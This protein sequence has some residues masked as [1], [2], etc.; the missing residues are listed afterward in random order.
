M[1]SLNWPCTCNFV[2]F[3]IVIIANCWAVW[4][5]QVRLIFENWSNNVN[6]SAWYRRYVINW[7]KWI[8]SS[9]CLPF[10]ISTTLSNVAWVM[11]IRLVVSW[12]LF[13]L[14]RSSSL[15]F[16]QTHCFFFKIPFL[17]IFSHLCP[18]NVANLKLIISPLRWSTSWLKDLN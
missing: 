8:R 12:I 2:G 9:F 14:T 17:F 7:L 11:Q 13:Q 1:W 6:S 10:R 3:N 4:L 5:F 18:L 15:N 16:I